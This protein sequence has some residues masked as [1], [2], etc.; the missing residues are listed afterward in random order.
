MGMAEGQ[1]VED[2]SKEI[3]DEEQLLG[4]K[5]EKGEKGKEGEN[6]P[7]QSKENTPETNSG[8]QK[9]TD[10]KKHERREI[11]EDKKSLILIIKKRLIERKM[12]LKT[13]KIIRCMIKTKK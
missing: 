13:R 4:L 10:F 12:K 9:R 6:Q 3:E 7:N 11:D 8:F 5:E 2:I 1:G